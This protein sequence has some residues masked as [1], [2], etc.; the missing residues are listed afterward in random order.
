MNPLRA[1]RLR[2]GALLNGRELDSEMDQEMRSHIEMQTRENLASGMSPEAARRTALREFGGIESIK[3]TCR[4]ER[5]LRWLEDLGSDVRFGTRQLRK[6]PGFTT[7]AALTLAL[8]VGVNTSMFSTLKRFLYAR[9]PYPEPNRLVRVFSADE[10]VGDSYLFQSSGDF[11]DERE[12][13]TVFQHLCAFGG[14]SRVNLSCSGSP[15][16]AVAVESVTP[17]FFATLGLPCVLGRTSP[18][19][20]ERR[21]GDEGIVLSQEFWKRHFNSDLQVLGRAL[22][23]DGK[24]ATVIGVAAIDD[25]L[26]FQGRVDVVRILAF[27]PE[28]RQERH[29]ARLTVVGRLKPGVTLAQTQ[30]E[31]AAI[32]QRIAHDHPE[33]HSQL[34]LRADTLGRSLMNRETH[35]IL[36]VLLALTGFVLL[37]ACANLVN[38]QLSRMT[39]RSREL[40]IRVA[41]GAG[42]LRLAR[43]LLTETVVLCLVGGTLG[44]LVAFACNSWL[45][46][47]FVLDYSDPRGLEIRLDQAVLSFAFLVSLLSALLV[48]TG[49]AWLMLRGNLN[50]ALK[51]GGRAHSPG[52]SSHRLQNTLIVA[53]TALALLLLVCGAERLTLETG[54]VLMRGPGWHPEGLTVGQI[55]LAGPNYDWPQKRQRFLMQLEERLCALPGVERVS[56]S[57]GLPFEHNSFWPLSVEGESELP[58]DKRTMTRMHEV[59]QNYF[60]TLGMALRQ[61]RDFTA[62]EVANTSPVVVISQAL[63]ERL[64]PGK[65]PIGRRFAPPGSDKYWMKVVG[66]VNHLSGSERFQAYRPRGGLEGFTLL[67][68]SSHTPQALAPILRQTMASLDRNLPVM[69]IQ[70][71]QHFLDVVSANDRAI[72]W[73][74]GGFG[75]LGMLLAAVGIYGVTAYVVSQR[76]NEFGIRLALGAQPTIVLW[77]VLRNGLRVSLLGALLGMAGAYALMRLL[78]ALQS[79]LDPADWAATAATAVLLVTVALLACWLPARRAT[80]TDPMTALRCE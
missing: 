49:P 5:G 36:W 63:A 17:E 44:L 38:L 24:P 21:E 7:V 78:G 74:V 58:P 69:E 46:Q 79:G 54:Q 19:D 22:R 66:V 76:T 9:V 61:G 40:G 73:L 14:S 6:H 65:D 20:G 60:R 64:W 27:P 2:F 15:A 4:D 67:I 62:D 50:P 77:L 32:G 41:L 45:G 18:A 29:D 33:A 25:P 13:S 23:L 31:I 26:L 28:R 71:A 12:Q 1:I 16:E 35:Q 68:R 59:D 53:Q 30:A 56:V 51:E 52:R 42:R 8:G 80:K 37:I 43:Q 11:L 70:S 75:S 34:S 47:Q 72:L 57:E 3:E 48:G 55:V 10:T 39:S